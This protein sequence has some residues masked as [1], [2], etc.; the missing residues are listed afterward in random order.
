MTDREIARLISRHEDFEFGLKVKAGNSISGWQCTNPFAGDL[1]RAVSTASEHQDAISYC[2]L[3]DD[4]ELS[5]QIRQLHMELDAVLPQSVFCASGA[6]ELLLSLCAFLSFKGIRELFYVPPLYFTVTY[7][8]R[9]LRIRPRPISAR[10]PFEP[11]FSMNLPPRQTVLFLTDPIWYAGISI[12]KRVI[13]AVASW[14]LDTQST[15]IV[16]GSFQ[17]M[18]WN[19]ST[20]ENTARLNP[21]STFRIL[22]PTKSLAVHGYRFAYVLLPKDNLPDFARTHSNLHGS[23]N[24]SSLAFAR[25]AISALRE[26]S[27]TNQLVTLIAERHSALR[28]KNRIGSSLQPDCTYFVFERLNIGLPSSHGLMDGMFFEQRRYPDHVRLNLLSPSIEL[29]L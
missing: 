26:R 14:Q 22:C 2:Y 8:L 5:R 17:Y 29:I 10:H 25:Q 6:T 18:R 11:E 20:E 1:I 27:I 9:L 15:V 19:G 13:D 7:A 21:E 3:E 28:S 12:P 16:D 4:I 24:T 23:S